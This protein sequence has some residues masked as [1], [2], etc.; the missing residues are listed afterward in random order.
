MIDPKTPRPA[1]A[2]ATEMSEI[3][4]P[5]HTNA[6]GSAFGGAIMSWI[7]ICGAIAAKRH[8][9]RVAVTAFVDDLAFLAP[10]RLGDVVRLTSRVTATFTTSLEVAVRVEQEDATT[11]AR[12][13]CADA[14][15]TFVAVDREGTPQPVPPLALETEED[16]RLS[17]EAQARRARRLERRRAR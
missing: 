17:D 16:R 4:L 10:I 3:V 8:C 9:G 2:S 5:Q 7:D 14:M 6:I 12:T 11:G 1:S 15:L 13:L